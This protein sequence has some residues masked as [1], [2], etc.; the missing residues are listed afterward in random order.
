M[1]DEFIRK[2]NIVHNNRYTYENAVYINANTKIIITCKEHGD[3]E[4]RPTNHLQGRGCRKCSNV[5]RY[6]TDEFIVQAKKK[7]NEIYTYDCTVYISSHTPVTITCITHGNFEQR[8][9]SHLRGVGCSKCRNDKFR[10]KLPEFILKA[11]E[12]HGDAYDYSKVDYVDGITKVVIVCPVHGDFRQTPRVHLTNH[13]CPQCATNGFRMDGNAFLYIQKLYIDDKI[14]G[15]K[16]GISKNIKKR[17]NAQSLVSLCT[18]EL[19]YSYESEAAEIFE[20]E[21]FIINEVYN[22]RKISKEILPDGHTESVSGEDNLY[23]IED[24]IK[25][26]FKNS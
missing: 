16:F 11:S 19:I 5:H 9:S 17:M 1:T 22:Y 2:A 20:L 12:L 18:H 6:S 7:H 14:I 4:Q 15:Y 25:K 21:R 3:F 10:M 13:G 26:F 8:P 24:A 23:L